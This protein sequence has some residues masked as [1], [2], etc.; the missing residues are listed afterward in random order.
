MVH[1]KAKRTAT[2]C[3]LDHQGVQ[4]VHQG[5]DTRDDWLYSARSYS[6]TVFYRLQRYVP[7]ISSSSTDTTDGHDRRPS[8]S[9]N[10][11]TPVSSNMDLRPPNFKNARSGSSS[12]IASGTSAM[13]SSHMSETARRWAPDTTPTPRQEAFGRSPLADPNIPGR[14]SFERRPSGMSAPMQPS[15]SGSGSIHSSGR[16]TPGA[17]SGSGM[18]GLGL[19]Q[20][21]RHSDPRKGSEASVYAEPMVRGGSR[22]SRD[23]SRP[24]VAPTPASPEARPTRP[25][26]AAAR[27]ISTASNQATPIAPTA[28][29]LNTPIAA[30]PSITTTD[31]S[32]AVPSKGKLSLTVPEHNDSAVSLS[33]TSPS[34]A[35]SPSNGRPRRRASFH[36]PPLETAFSR[37]V[38]LTSRTTQLPG[39]AG[40]TVDDDGSKGDAV[41]TSVEEMLEGFDWT[42]PAL[43][44]DGAKKRGADAIEARLSDELAALDSV[45]P[46]VQGSTT[47]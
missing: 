30:P 34:S 31:A 27:N 12:S 29:Q 37:E 23:R 43:G 44:S 17:G 45:C 26:R 1:R 28:S 36:P 21:P 13:S 14:T 8:A 4:D 35:L 18:N 46:S 5:Q 16:R 15:N 39:V 32:P 47:S 38:L 25:A 9:S 42:A 2:F 19:G 7:P 11:S 40:M 33:P 24:I 22:D 20:P 10:T 6:S 3:Q 41:M